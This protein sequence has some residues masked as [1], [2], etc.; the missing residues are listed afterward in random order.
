MTYVLG[1][2]STA[3]REGGWYAKVRDAVLKRHPILEG[4]DGLGV[5]TLNL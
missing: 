5:S 4:L 3:P 2:G 1:A